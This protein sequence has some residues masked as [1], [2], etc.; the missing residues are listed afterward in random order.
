[1]RCDQPG[2]EATAFHRLD[3]EAWNGHAGEASALAARTVHGTDA[4]PRW[5]AE[6]TRLAA[7]MSISYSETT[8]LIS[9]PK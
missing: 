1:L 2:I 7:D 5:C 4:K 6:W 8:A 9:S 3:D